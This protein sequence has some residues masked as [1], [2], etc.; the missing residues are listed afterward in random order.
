MRSLQRVFQK[1]LLLAV[2]GMGLT[3]CGQDNWVKD[4]QVDVVT[5]RGQVLADVDVFL[6]TGGLQLAAT[7]LPIYAPGSLSQIG[8]FG[9]YPS[10]GSDAHNHVLSLSL[11]VSDALSLPEGLEP[12]LPNGDT[13]PLK[14]MDKDSVLSFP[15]G[16][17][18]SRIYLHV[19]TQ[20]QNL[21][22]G[23]AVT[24]EGLGNPT[25]RTFSLFGPAPLGSNVQAW[26]G[27]FFGVGPKTNGFGVFLTAKLDG[28][29]LKQQSSKRT[30]APSSEVFEERQV[31]SGTR[32]ALDQHML[33]LHNR[34]A[35]LRVH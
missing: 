11:N 31:T 3:G 10:V 7:T 22:I 33:E 6:D 26:F 18:S 4:A 13:L 34:R 25:G 17:S 1:S 9:L 32:Q 14:G 19:N 16:A 35:T 20:T 8:S 23:S 30:T 5:D 15:V 24:L 27:T 21:M 28:S 29:L 2:L 12:I